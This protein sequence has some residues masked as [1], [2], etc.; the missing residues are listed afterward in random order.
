MK[1]VKFHPDAESELIDAAKFYEDKQAQLGK[2]YLQ[3]VS[4]TVERISLNPSIYRKIGDEIR[5]ARTSTFPFVIIFR[6]K[7]NHIEIL[8][9]MHIR[10]QPGYWKTRQ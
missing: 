1:T 7:E 9:V 2:R 5:C 6:E 4:Q 10:R 3:A 8:A